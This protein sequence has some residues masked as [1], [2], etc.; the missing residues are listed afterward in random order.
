M[1]AH[2][3]RSQRI[4]Y[5][6]RLSRE[7]EFH[8]HGGG[9]YAVF[10]L[11][12][13]VFPS[14]SRVLIRWESSCQ[15]TPWY[16]PPRLVPSTSFE[17]AEEVQRNKSAALACP[18]RVASFLPFRLTVVSR[19]RASVIYF[20]VAAVARSSHTGFIGV[21][22]DDRNHRFSSPC[23]KRFRHRRS[24]ARR[25]LARATVDISSLIRL[26]EAACSCHLS[27]W[28]LPAKHPR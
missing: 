21:N 18:R 26:N 7:Y 13:R 14:I 2:D 27:P 25:L 22:E 19:T 1:I 8:I 24:R 12:P 10:L 15:W 16:L 4:I 6:S 20:Y 28:R 11:V 5:F 17:M 9:S 23:D 3:G